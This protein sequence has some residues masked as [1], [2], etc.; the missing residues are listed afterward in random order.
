MTK[1][2]TARQ[3][4]LL[5]LIRDFTK[6]QGFPPSRRDLLEALGV[7]ST[8]TIVCLLKALEVRKLIVV[9]PRTARG[10][11]LTPESVAVVGP[12]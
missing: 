1:K 2:I 9:L 8:N 6:A 10:I 4:E 11:T 3:K 12:V 5:I 7:T